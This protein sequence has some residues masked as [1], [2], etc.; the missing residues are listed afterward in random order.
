MTRFLTLLTLALA[1]AIGACDDN[2]PPDPGGSTNSEIRDIVWKLV[3]I[4][5]NGATQTIDQSQAI[6]I[7]FGATTLDGFGPCN[8]YTGSFAI[9]DVTMTISSFTAGADA[10]AAEALQTEYFD[11]LKAV[12]SYVATATTLRM[13]ARGGAVV[14]NYT[15]STTVPGNDDVDT[16]GHS[17]ILGGA[18]R[19]IGVDL[20]G[21]IERIPSPRPVVLRF[22]LGDTPMLGGNGPCNPFTGTYTLGSRR[23]IAITSFNAGNALCDDPEAKYFGYLRASDSFRLANGE[24][25]LIF[26]DGTLHYERYIPDTI[27]NEPKRPLRIAGAEWK[28]TGISNGGMMHPVRDERI[29]IVFDTNRS[30][31][32]Q[33]PR[34]GGVNGFGKCSRFR[35]GYT[36]DGMSIE[37]TELSAEQLNCPTTNLEIDHM[38]AFETAMR[39]VSD[40]TTLQIHCDGGRILY[41]V[42]PA[43]APLPP[44]DLAILGAWK[45]TSMNLR[46]DVVWTPPGESVLILRPDLSLGGKGICNNMSGRF[47]AF[48]GALELTEFAYTEASCEGGRILEQRYFETLRKASGYRMRDNDN[49]TITTENGYEIHYVRLR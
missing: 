44:L 21:R 12:Q 26:D 46:D 39:W 5:S 4:E 19:L 9:D 8:R 7:E 47:A 43:V 38:R 17:E 10:C 23:T 34:D 14:L 11:A 42:N 31:P 49:L 25:H 33:Q 2:L 22:G 27:P 16:V 30:A 35:A 13:Y 1:L 41:Y 18:W 29:V 37:I 45:L 48:G 20:L 6:S 32:G 40:D 15:K 3:S 28:L 36:H 24:L